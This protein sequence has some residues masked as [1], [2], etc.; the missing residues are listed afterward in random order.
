MNNGNAFSPTLNLLT[1]F[2]LIMFGLLHIHIEGDE[3]VLLFGLFLWDSVCE[4]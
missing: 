4:L 2:A 3:S 1:I